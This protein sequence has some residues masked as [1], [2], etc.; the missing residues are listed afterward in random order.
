MRDDARNYSHV[1]SSMKQAA[2]EK[3][4]EMLLASFG[5]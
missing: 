2:T 5:Q 4:E 1:P 3:L